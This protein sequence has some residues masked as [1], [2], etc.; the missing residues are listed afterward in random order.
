MNVNLQGLQMCRILKSAGHK[1]ILAD[2]HKFRFSA[3]R[4]SNSVDKWVTLPNLDSGLESEENYKV[5][6]WSESGIKREYLKVTNWPQM[7]QS[8]IL[9]CCMAANVSPPAVQLY[10]PGASVCF[11]SRCPCVIK[12]MLSG[13]RTEKM[14]LG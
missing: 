6:G 2:L 11:E 14:C 4:F 12:T 7:G 1:V 8:T 10:W 5:T 3:A 9:K 13:I